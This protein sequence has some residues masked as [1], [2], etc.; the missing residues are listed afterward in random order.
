MKKE[1]KPLHYKVLLLVLISVFATMF[2]FACVNTSSNS[3]NTAASHNSNVAPNHPPAHKPKPNTQPSTNLQSNQ[4]IQAFV[5]NMTPLFQ[6]ALRLQTSKNVTLTLNKATILPGGMILLNYSVSGIKRNASEPASLYYIYYGISPDHKYMW[7]MTSIGQVKA[8]ENLM[9]KHGHFE[10]VLPAQE[11]LYGPV[12]EHPSSNITNLDQLKYVAGVLQREFQ[13]SVYEGT[14]DATAAKEAKIY[15]DK[16]TPLGLYTNV[17]VRLYMPPVQTPQGTNPS[18]V[19]PRQMAFTND[20]RFILSQK[21]KVSEFKDEVLKEKQR[22]SNRPSSTVQVKADKP[23]IQLFVMAY[24][25]YGLQMEK[26]ILPVIERFGDKVNFTVEFVDYSMHPQFNESYENLVQYCIQKTQ[27]DK[28]LAY[29]SCFIQN[30]SYS[31]SNTQTDTQNCLRVAGIDQQTL[32]QCIKETDEKYNVMYDYN[33]RNTWEGGQ[34][35]PFNVEKADNIKYAVQGS[36]TLVINGQ[37]VV[38]QGRN[39]EALFK[40]ICSAFTHPPAICNTTSFPTSSEA[41]G[42]GVIG[43]GGS[44]AGAAGHCG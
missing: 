43:Q 14:F 12:F 26:A 40:L 3:G 4:S 29:L 25:P 39:Q 8:I 37:V 15:F 6:T 23:T 41:P 36:P 38:P 31:S 16:V 10:N 24:C 1:N 2:L 5:A 32:D 7:S 9:E 13:I 18:R 33:H 20:F 21:I 30:G 42:F 35:P 34:F 28:Y 27:K 17:S 22:I 19:I 44:S 11:Q